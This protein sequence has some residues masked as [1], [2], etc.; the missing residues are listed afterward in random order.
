MLESTKE[1]QEQAQ[2]HPKN[3]GSR[4]LAEQ[5]AAG[6]AVI[7]LLNRE[8]FSLIWE[9][10]LAES[11]EELMRACIAESD[12]AQPSDE[13][14]RPESTSAEKDGDILEWYMDLFRCVWNG[15]VRQKSTPDRLLVRPNKRYTLAGFKFVLQLAAHAKKVWGE[16]GYVFFIAFLSRK[17]PATMLYNF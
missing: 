14:K 9:R 10:T 15:S 11:S 5:N 12:A 17:T 4:K 13:L 3:V 1:V 2:T 8:E 7:R 16:D 6:N